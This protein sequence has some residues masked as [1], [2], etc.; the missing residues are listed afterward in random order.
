VYAAPISRNAG[1]PPEQVF[2][3]KGSL[4]GF[5]IFSAA[6][7][8]VEIYVYEYISFDNVKIFLVN[9]NV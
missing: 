3:K 2:G 5:I 1:F 9:K 8:R 6:Q 4:Q 7:R